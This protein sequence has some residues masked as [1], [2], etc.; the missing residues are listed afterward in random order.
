MAWPYLLVHP[1]GPTQV[2]IHSLHGIE[3]L[4]RLGFESQW[5]GMM[6]HHSHLLAQQ[7]V[8]MQCWGQ[9]QFH[10]IDSGSFNQESDVLMEGRYPTR[11]PG[12]SKTSLRRELS[13]MTLK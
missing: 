7:K 1:E 5:V 2:L 3:R 13:Q 11:S 10:R 9:C 6:K 8:L 4:S 12:H